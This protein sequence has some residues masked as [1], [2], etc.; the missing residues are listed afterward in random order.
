MVSW[1]KLKDK[2]RIKVG[3]QVLLIDT[4]TLEA[5]YKLAQ[6]ILK[7]EG[8]LEIKDEQVSKLGKQK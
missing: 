4:K 2:H 7:D 6:E 1:I 3:N 8:T 5:L